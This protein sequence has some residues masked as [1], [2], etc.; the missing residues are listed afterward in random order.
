MMEEMSDDYKEILDRLISFPLKSQIKIDFD[1]TKRNFL[2]SIPI[3]FSRSTLPHSVKEYVEARKNHRFKPHETSFQFDGMNRVKLVQ[4]LPFQ[5]GFQPG[6]RDQIM[7][8]WKLAKHCH[9]LLV[10]LAV[11]E[12]YRSALHLDSDFES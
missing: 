10:E 3:F 2:L 12:K 9:R 5:W 11:E 8:F 7:A 6:L 4:E 1:S